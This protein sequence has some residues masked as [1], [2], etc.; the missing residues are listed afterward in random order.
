MVRRMSDRT[1]AF[2]YSPEIDR[3]S[4]PPECPFKAQR[5]G[6]TRHQLKLF[7]LLG[8]D[9]RFEV[10][11]RR[12]S[13]RELQR[14]HTARYLD[15]L[16]RAARGGLTVEG[17]RM[18][19]GGADTPVFAD[20]FEYGAWA[21]GAGLNAAGLLVEHKADVVFNLLGG[22]HHAAAERAEGFCY[23]NDV[24]LS[25]MALA[26]A[27]KRVASVDLDAHHGDG[28]QRSRPA[29]SRKVAR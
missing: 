8:D 23:L 9:S 22:F 4:Y 29:L 15:E 7:G 1:L 28:S 10:T 5:A 21:C 24:V 2:L 17:F 6:L 13:V 16:Q 19:L 25:C 14:F 18:G 3:L 12:A 26:D 11:A 20:M 27:G